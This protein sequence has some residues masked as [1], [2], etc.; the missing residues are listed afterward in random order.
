MSSAPI[1]KMKGKRPGAPAGKGK[2]KPK[3]KGK[4]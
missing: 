2:T 3:K 1:E 4:C